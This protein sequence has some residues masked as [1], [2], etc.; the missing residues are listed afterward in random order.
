[1]AER[2]VPVRLFLDEALGSGAAIESPVIDCRKGDLDHVL[3][4]L[5]GTGTPSVKIQVAI[6]EDGTTF[7][8]YDA[9]DDVIAATATEWASEEAEM[10]SFLVT[11]A[12]P[13]LKIKLTE[14]ATLADCTVTMVGM[15]K[16]I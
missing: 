10:H 1:M 12:A 5:S 8:S 15:L 9:Q 13:F 2:L 11:T 7:N 16:E 4:T 6:S 14:L 3:L